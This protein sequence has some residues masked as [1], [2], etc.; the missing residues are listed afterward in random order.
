MFCSV[1]S[2]A[3]YGVSCLKVS[4]E[5]SVSGGLPNFQ[6][7][8]LLSSEVREA[9]ERVS[10]AVT[11]SGYEIFSRK[12]TV[13]LAPADI[14]KEGSA[15]D[16]PIAMAILCGLGFVNEKCMEDTVFAGELG[17]DG[18]LKEITGILPIAV[19][20]YDENIKR[21]IVPAGNVREAALIEGVE[22]LGFECLKDIVDY[23]NGEDAEVI[24]PD[25]GQSVQKEI[26]YAD[27]KDVLGQQNAKRG[28]E[29]AAAG[30]HNLLL[31][32]PPGSGKTMIA[33]R[34]PSILH[35]LSKDEMLE[36]AK[37][38][39]IMGMLNP[40]VMFKRPFREPSNTVSLAGLMGG[41]ANP[42]PGEVTLANKGVLFLDEFPEFKR[43]TI[44]ALRLPLEEKKIRV[45]RSGG[46]VTFPADFMLVAAMNPCHCG[47]Y[48]DRNKC[49]CLERDIK[50]YQSKV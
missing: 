40:D 7:V 20:A 14:R 45:S 36:V 42:R 39:S 38:Y 32:G 27:F 9:K 37:V 18:S 15:F 49:N 16:L 28:A 46:T 21:L 12:I 5:V 33:K 17:L 35:S 2:A 6:M 31:I 1:F 41:K 43:E 47:Y 24:V 19:M 25:V 8:G 11:N 22:V 48:P 29:I 44:E 13:N 3:L 26:P 10:A 4:V 23:Y 34:I 50:K 30:M